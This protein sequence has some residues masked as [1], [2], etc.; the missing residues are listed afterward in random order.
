VPKEL[1]S[2][3]KQKLSAVDPSH[4]AQ[5]LPEILT[6]SVVGYIYE[7]RAKE[8]RTLLDAV[9][10]EDRKGKGAYVSAIRERMLLAP[11]AE[12]LKAELEILA[13]K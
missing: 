1:I 8:A 11:F 9:W 4:P 12:D 3:I 2:A 10:P 5:D 6:S 7:G 13:G